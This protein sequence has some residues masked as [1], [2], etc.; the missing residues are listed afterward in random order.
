[1]SAAPAASTACALPDAGEIHLAV[2]GA[3]RWAV[4][5]RLAVFS[6][7]VRGRV[8]RPLGRHGHGTRK[9]HGYRRRR[10]QV[11]THEASSRSA[12]GPTLTNYTTEV[13]RRRTWPASTQPWSRSV[14]RPPAYCGG[15][16]SGMSGPSCR[17]G[18]PFIQA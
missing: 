12:E 2:G 15:V 4:E 9:R 16:L 18:S 13:D 7:H 6:G 8:G 1:R 5:D 3:R 10:S 11:H 17:G 14:A